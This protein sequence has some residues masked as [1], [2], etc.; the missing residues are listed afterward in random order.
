MG[1]SFRVGCYI[2]VR[3]YTTLKTF[4]LHAASIEVTLIGLRTVLMSETQV[5]FLH[6]GVSRPDAVCTRYNRN[7]S[8]CYIQINWDRYLK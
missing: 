7:H 5:L 4:D 3:V 1:D 6:C 2:G 8:I